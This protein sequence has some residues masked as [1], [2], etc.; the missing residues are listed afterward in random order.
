MAAAAGKADRTVKRRAKRLCQLARTGDAEQLA[1][2]LGPENCSGL[3][4]AGMGGNTALMVA[5]WNDRADCVALLLAHGADVDKGDPSY[6][7]T[8]LILAAQYG[9]LSAAR[10]LVEAGASLSC[11]LTEGPDKG[12]TARALALGG[13]SRVHADPQPGRMVRAPHSKDAS[14]GRGRIDSQHSAVGELLSRAER[15]LVGARQRLAF[16][17]CLLDG[18]GQLGQQIFGSRLPRNADGGCDLVWAGPPVATVN[19]QH[20][21]ESTRPSMLSTDEEADLASAIAASLADSPT[22][23]PS[24]AACAWP[25][26]HPPAC[27]C[28]HHKTNDGGSSSTSSSSERKLALKIAALDAAQQGCRTGP[29][30][31]QRLRQLKDEAQALRKTR[32]DAIIATHSRKQQAIGA[33]AVIDMARLTEVRRDVYGGDGGG[34][35]S[36]MAWLSVIVVRQKTLDATLVTRHAH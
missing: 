34:A 21:S 4:A 16:A 15:A 11:T 32:L 13:S 30:N 23:V 19:E 28:C 25:H 24:P 10:L 6:G 36:V 14:V 33:P 8:P 22:G 2:L 27:T 5:A 3:D 17:T 7:Y 31:F 9:A 20:A 18:H 26:L 12:M 35:L 29:F 1:T